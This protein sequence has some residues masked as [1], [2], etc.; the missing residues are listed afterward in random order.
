MINRNS[1]DIETIKYN[2]RKIN[3][4]EHK[5]IAYDIL[6]EFSKFCDNNNLKYFLAYGTLIGAV[7]HN[8]FIPWDDDIDVQMP[9]KDYNKL[10]K[11]FND[12]INNSDLKL[13]SPFE[14]KAKFTFVKICNMKT[15]KIESGLDYSDGFYYG[16]DIDVFPI[17]GKMTNQ[18][19]YKKEFIQLE[20]M[21]KLYN[22]FCFKQDLTSFR[23]KILGRITSI[24]KYVVPSIK[25]KIMK[26]IDFL[27]SKHNFETSETVG[28]QM[29][30]YNYF[31]EKWS[32]KAFDETIEIKFEKDFFKCPKGYDEVL[33]N[34]YGNYMELPPVEERVSTHLN[35]VYIERK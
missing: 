23:S 8:G 20:R 24:I 25:R 19:L 32:K 33:K 21:F 4:D 12:K 26:K 5:K 28:T 13:I 34:I 3:V 1:L 17:D 7:R 27:A 16:I 31:T 29:F 15:V 35:D 18:A 30:L 2:F 10:I 9:R 14:D 11:I 6:V 22:Y